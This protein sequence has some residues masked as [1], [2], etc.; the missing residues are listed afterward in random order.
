MK[1][2]QDDNSSI[3]PKSKQT[4]LYLIV[5]NVSHI[6]MSLKETIQKYTAHFTFESIEMNDKKNTPHY[7][8][9]KRKT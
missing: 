6:K 4:Q 8:M 3:E 1:Q 9:T 7:E 5:E 2:S